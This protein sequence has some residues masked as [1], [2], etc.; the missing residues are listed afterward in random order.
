M[1]FA[2]ERRSPARVLVI[3]I[4]ACGLIYI[5]YLGIDLFFFNKEADAITKIME[6][7]RE[8]KNNPEN[9]KEIWAILNLVA[10][11]KQF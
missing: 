4:F 5:W 11:F 2:I 9:E 8:E 7:D 3:V 1:F 6:K 10:S